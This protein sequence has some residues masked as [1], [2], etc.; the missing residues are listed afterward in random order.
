MKYIVENW[1][2]C[3]DIIAFD[4]EEQ[5]QK[6]LDENVNQSPDG[7]FL[8]DGTQVGIYEA[9]SHPTR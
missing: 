9:E 6:W 1:L 2:T 8:K 4:T 7:G 5:R 3:E